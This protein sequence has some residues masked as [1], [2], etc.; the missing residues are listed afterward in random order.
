M[1][2]SCSSQFINDS[3]CDKSTDKD[4]P[5]DGKYIFNTALAIDEKGNLVAK[6][7]KM[8]IFNFINVFDTPKKVDIV[9]F[10]TY[11]GVRFGMFICYDIMFPHPPYDLLQ[12]NITHFGYPTRFICPY[13]PTV[14]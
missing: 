9:Y 8:H 3:K 4:C 1:F 6:Y 13:Q 12:L 11:F 7:Y 2:R 5:S 14:C 10:D